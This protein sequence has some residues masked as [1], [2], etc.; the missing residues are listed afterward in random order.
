ML[1]GQIVGQAA[2]IYDNGFSTLTQSYG[3]EARGGA[4]TAEVVISD[5]PIDY[6]YV[7]LP[8]VTIILSQEAYNNF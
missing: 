6:P 2:S 8:E 3:P 5:E 7:T 4:C 1:S